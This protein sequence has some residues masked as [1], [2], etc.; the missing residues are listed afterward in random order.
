MRS[1][2]LFLGFYFLS[3]QAFGYRPAL[4]LSYTFLADIGLLAIVFMKEKLA[5][6]STVTGLAVFVFLAIWTAW[7]LTTQNLYAA[8]AAFFVF[9]LLH[10]AASL[11]LQR[12]RKIQMQWWG[13]L[14]PGLA[15]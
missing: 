6:V 7:Y 12:V 13:H 9:A 8:L 5:A 4:L 3:F 1:R 10:S 2:W 15:L 11:V 14:F